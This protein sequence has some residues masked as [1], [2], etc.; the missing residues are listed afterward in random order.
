MIYPG[1][2]F[3]SSKTLSRYSAII[4]IDNKI[5]PQKKE[6]IIRVV[7]HPGILKPPNCSC[8]ASFNIMETIITIIDS[9]KESSPIQ[10]ISF[11]GKLEEA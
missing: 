3:T 1:L 2:F 6:I 8:P 7:V 4:L 9:I 10:E 5:N 11:M